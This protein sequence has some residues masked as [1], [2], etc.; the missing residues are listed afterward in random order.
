MPTGASFTSPL[1]S[2]ALGAFSQMPKGGPPVMGGGDWYSVGEWTKPPT[3]QT[4]LD[5][6]AWLKRIGVPENTF[7][8][9]SMNPKTGQYALR[10]TYDPTKDWNKMTYSDFARN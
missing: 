10:N 9:F 6:N 1:S 3:G 5:W 4:L 2:A 7:S 8:Q